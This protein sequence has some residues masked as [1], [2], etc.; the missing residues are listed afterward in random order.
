MLAVVS[1]LRQ[2]GICYVF[3]RH[4]ACEAW[5]REGECYWRNLLTYWALSKNKGSTAL[6]IGLLGLAKLNRSIENFD[7]LLS[8]ALLRQTKSTIARVNSAID[9]LAIK[10]DK[11]CYSLL[12]YWLN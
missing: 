12:A 9:F 7:F 8:I 4:F 1:R 5:S 2:Q 10:N 3:V 11:K 6:A